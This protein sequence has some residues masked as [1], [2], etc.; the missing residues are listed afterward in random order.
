[1]SLWKKLTEFFLGPE[2]TAARSTPV[3]APLAGTPLEAAVW[4]A[5]LGN[6]QAG[7][8][9]VAVDIADAA[10]TGQPRTVE[11]ITKA[12]QVVH[13]LFDRGMF[14]PH[15]YTRTLL[16]TPAGTNWVYHP[17]GSIPTALAPLAA[18]GAVKP[19]VAS[20]PSAAKGPLVPQGSRTPS[21]VT[22]HTASAGLPKDPYDLGVFLTLTPAEHR[23]RALKINPYK[24]AW[25]GRVDVIPP[26][27]DERTALIDRGLELR[28]LLSRDEIVEIHRIG[29][30]WLKHKDAARLA[31]S[32]AHKN[33][34]ELLAQER[35]AKLLEKARKKDAAAAKR[36]RA[37]EDV[38]KRKREDIVY[39]GRGG[40][41]PSLSKGLAD[42]RSNIE[43]LASQALPR[44][45]SPA[46]VARALEIDVKKLRFLAFH[47]D[48]QRHVHY[49]H[50]E[51]PKKKGGTRRLSAPKPE[52]AKAQRWILDNV[53]ERL[54]VD[55][56]AHGFV[57]ERSTVTN[58]KPHQGKA[59][60]VNQDLVDFFPTIT[61]ARVRS[62]FERAGYSPA[63]ATIFALLTTECPRQKAT[64]A[65]HEYHV[66]VGP[67][68]LPQ[69][70][71][72]SPALSNLVAARL[73]RRLAGYTQKHGWTYT[74]YADDLTFSAD[75]ERGAE[76][77][78][79]SLAKLLATLHHI[80]R[81]E[82]FAIHPDKGRVQRKSKRQ[83]VTGI[84]V[85]EAQKLGVPREEV[86]LLRAILH[87][88]KKTGLAAQN[89]EL[90]P[91]FEA[92]LRGKIAYITMVD[93]A[94]GLALQKEL[95]ALDL[96][97]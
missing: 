85:N 59:I 84:I 42:R 2:P 70:A 34:E 93:R 51:V 26:E 87:N 46:D 21:S 28:G 91:T 9:F 3:P 24:T 63:V 52:L 1:M 38:A 79:G 56:H 49:V 36:A 11:T 96:G 76:D 82:G 40:Q 81:A 14:A 92:W 69:G 15:G 31:E 97:R 80:A 50:F 25:I 18:P 86:R 88:A 10:T 62:I 20:A 5:C 12:V 45:S 55:R 60:V 13:E 74:R 66:A 48:A 35:T 17:K 47:A 23:A 77:A 37:A 19:P 89:R 22:G 73:D 30:L 67:R 95:D 6:I 72:T 33:V 16:Q 41:I 68:G 43:K 58:A 8:H 29:D 54:V 39:L 4:A 65:G 32:I 44:L 53:L 75:D 83:T 61:F 27:S 71:C 57:K 64:Y 90:S 78:G 7:S 94:R